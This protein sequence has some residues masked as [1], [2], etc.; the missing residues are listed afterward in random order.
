MT[1]AP[2]RKKVSSFS[3]GSIVAGKK[4]LAHH[5]DEGTVDIQC[6]LC[7]CR[8]TV[9][10]LN[11]YAKKG[12]GCSQRNIVGVH[13]LTKSDRK[14][15]DAM[16]QTIVAECERYIPQQLREHWEYR[17]ISPR[18]HKDNPDRYT[19][20]ILDVGERPVGYRA[21]LINPFGDFTPEN[22]CWIPNDRGNKRDDSPSIP[23]GDGDFIQDW[24]GEGGEA[25]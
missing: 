12:C 18:W 13:T 15:V 10:S 14:V 6:L 3:P 24:K 17:S 9:S 22:F 2:R 25:E 1:R 21:G 11:F 16:N 4:I 5:P 7:G 23:E 19:N 20:F 8:G